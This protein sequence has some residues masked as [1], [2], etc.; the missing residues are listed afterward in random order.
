[1]AS[2]GETEDHNEESKIIKSYRDAISDDIPKEIYFRDNVEVWS[3]DVEEDMV[4]S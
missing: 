4:D 2:D 1:M 3:D